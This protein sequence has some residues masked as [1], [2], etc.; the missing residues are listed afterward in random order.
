MSVVML[1]SVIFGLRRSA[2]TS[3]DKLRVARLEIDVS[4]SVNGIWGFGI[5]KDFGG[6]HGW[7]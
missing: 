3:S 2:F 1:R 6:G 5:V 4:W 7:T